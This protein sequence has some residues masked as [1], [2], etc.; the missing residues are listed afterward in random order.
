MIIQLY[1]YIGLD[2]S[3]LIQEL[4][5]VAVE[6]YVLGR[7]LKVPNHLLKGIRKSKSSCDEQLIDML[8]AWLNN[9]IEASYKDIVCAL[10]YMNQ[11][12]LAKKLADKHGKYSEFICIYSLNNY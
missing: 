7:L 8:D 2:D 12:S 10:Q 11:A 9:K 4:I 1:N 6:W 3:T 5:G